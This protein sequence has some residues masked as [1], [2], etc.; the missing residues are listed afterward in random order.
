[1][2]KTRTSM[3]RSRAKIRALFERSHRTSP[4]AKPRIE[5]RA[6]HNEIRLPV[7][8]SATM[9]MEELLRSIKALIEQAGV[10]GPDAG[11][12][13]APDE[14]GACAQRAKSGRSG[15]K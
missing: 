13:A 4:V 9:S 8:G 11:A 14:E 3:N 7:A 1:M 10:A 6:L 2:P 15:V 5:R 12:E